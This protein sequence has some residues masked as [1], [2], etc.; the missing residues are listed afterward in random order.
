MN[1]QELKEFFVKSDY[2]D[3]TK[4][5]INKILIDKTEVTPGLIFQVKDILQTELDLDFKELGV[6]GPNNPEV[7]EL[8]KEYIKTLDTIQ[9]DLDGDMNF[10][11]KE[12]TEL[13]ELRK[14]VLKSSD[15]MEAEKIKQS[16]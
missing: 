14:N 10:V 8:E 13:E 5:A 3:S 7:Q 2:S 4:D 12:F 9:K 15:E 1:I 11:E 16:M 6:D